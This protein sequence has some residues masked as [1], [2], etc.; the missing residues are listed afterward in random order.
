MAADIREIKEI[1]LE[2]I[3]KQTINGKALLSITL[4]DE[5]SPMKL[6][7]TEDVIHRLQEKLLGSYPTKAVNWLE[8]NGHISTYHR[9][10]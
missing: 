3:P 5:S 10:C 6:W 1:T 2:A 4:V 8:A 9:G 7:A